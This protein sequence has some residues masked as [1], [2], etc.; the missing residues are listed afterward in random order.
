M[1]ASAMPL[2]AALL[3]ALA[4]LAVL[5]R[6][7]CMGIGRRLGRGGSFGFTSE[8]TTFPFA[9]FA[10]EVMNLFLQ[11][12]FALDGALML[13]PPKVGLLTKFDD[14]EP[15]PTQQHESNKKEGR[16]CA[17]ASPQE[18]KDGTEVRL[19]IVGCI[20]IDDQ[21]CRD[22]EKRPLLGWKTNQGIGFINVHAP[23]MVGSAMA[24]K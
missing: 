24:L 2:A 20:E 5:G 15:Q 1:I 13:G 17:E 14:L 22:G 10:L 8:E 19:G 18:S 12:G 3:S 21:L 11:S 6:V 23:P 9:D 7:F 16:E 4:W